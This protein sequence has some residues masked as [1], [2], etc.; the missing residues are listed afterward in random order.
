MSMKIYH[1]EDASFDVM[2]G[3][4]IAVLGY[5]SQGRAQALCFRDSGLDVIVGVRKDGKSWKQA[6]EDGG[7]KVM[8]MAEAVKEG[9]VVMMLLPDET[10]PDIYKDIVAPN[11]KSGAALEFAHGFAITYGLIVPPKDVDVIMMAPKSPGASERKAFEDGFGVTALFCV[12]QDAS[13]KARAPRRGNRH[14]S[15]RQGRP[16]DAEVHPAEPLP[17]ALH[18]RRHHLRD[19]GVRQGVLR[20][21]Q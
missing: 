13:G 12:H 21:S 17:R 7:M 11:L 1:D 19:Q 2:K 14:R 16:R 6:K 9:D 15:D 5:G 8:E 10:Q 20:V 4:K 18:H 3:K